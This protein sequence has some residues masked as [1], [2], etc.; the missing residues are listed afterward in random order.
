MAASEKLPEQ[1][2]RYRILSLLGRGGMGTVYRAE[3]MALQR[4]VALKTLYLDPET[5]SEQV[6]RF[7][8]EA[9]ATARLAHPN[10]CSIFDVGEADGVFYYAM[11]YLEGKPLSVYIRQGWRFGPSQIAAMI[12]TIA[13]ALAHVHGLGII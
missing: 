4:I 10:I 5:R 1:I 7:Y 13:L 9:R 6:D 11:A 2:G 3:D 8:R 12:R